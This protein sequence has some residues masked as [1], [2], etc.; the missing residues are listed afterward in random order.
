M[1]LKLKIT[2]HYIKD[3]ISPVILILPSLASSPRIGSRSASFMP[4][5]RLKVL[6]SIFPPLLER[7]HKIRSRGV[8]II[9]SA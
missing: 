2:I 8:C 4:K 1:A 9:L 6:R 5:R 3:I 7:I